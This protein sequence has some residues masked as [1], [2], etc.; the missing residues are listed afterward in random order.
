MRTDPIRTPKASQNASQ[1]Q[2]LSPHTPRERELRESTPAPRVAHSEGDVRS[3]P[4]G[5]SGRV[6]RSGAGAANGTSSGRSRPSCDSRRRISLGASGSRCLPAAKPAGHQ[7]RDNWRMG[8]VGNHLPQHRRPSPPS[9]CRYARRIRELEPHLRFFAVTLAAAVC[10]DF[11][12]RRATPT[13]T[14]YWASEA[15][16]AKGWTTDCARCG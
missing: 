16:S 4:G 2:R 15:V 10:A 8:R 1:R 11:S 5:E 9:H 3:R 6:L 7:L 14:L 12:A 13:P